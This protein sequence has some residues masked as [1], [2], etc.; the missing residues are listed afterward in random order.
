M[1]GTSELNTDLRVRV[2][3]EKRQRIEELV[4]ERSEPGHRVTVS[5]ILRDALD[6]YLEEHDEDRAD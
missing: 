1:S 2:S 6:E 5:D 3:Q 4:D